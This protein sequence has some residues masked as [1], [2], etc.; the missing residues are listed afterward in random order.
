MFL[1][2]RKENPQDVKCFK[3]DGPNYISQFVTPRARLINVNF[4][5]YI[6]LSINQFIFNI[7]ICIT[8]IL[9][10]FVFLVV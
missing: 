9:S 4:T 3:L 8:H 2:Q 1:A 10:C 5:I 6:F 7:C